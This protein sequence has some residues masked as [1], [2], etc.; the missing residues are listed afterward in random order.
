M[1]SHVRNCSQQLSR[2]IWM[3][4]VAFAA[5]AHVSEQHRGG[6]GRAAEAALGGHRGL[7]IALKSQGTPGAAAAAAKKPCF[8]HNA[9][10]C[11]K[12]REPVPCSHTS[13]AASSC[14]GRTHAAASQPRSGLVLGRGRW[15]REPPPRGSR[16]EEEEGREIPTSRAELMQSLR[17]LRGSPAC[18]KAFSRPSSF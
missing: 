11:G 7:G 8:T 12:E 10:S 3:R 9:S 17:R 14:P 15:L 6:M 4:P 13:E 16:E 5:P 18:S 2:C 1:P